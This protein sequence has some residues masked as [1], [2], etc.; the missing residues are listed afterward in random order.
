MIEMMGSEAGQSNAPAS[1]STALTRLEPLLKRE[2]RS[3]ESTKS[4]YHIHSFPVSSEAKNTF[5]LV[6]VGLDPIGLSG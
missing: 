3:G 1:S 2:P 5:Q 6:L 4:I